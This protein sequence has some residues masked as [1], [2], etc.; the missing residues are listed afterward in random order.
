MKPVTE[1]KTEGTDF[2]F[3]VQENFYIPVKVDEIH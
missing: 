2:S 3:S 1:N